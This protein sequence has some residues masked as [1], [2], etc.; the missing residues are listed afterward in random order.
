MLTINASTELAEFATNHVYSILTAL[1]YNNV[2]KQP[3][4]RGFCKMYYRSYG[5]NTTTERCQQFAFGGCDGNE[6]NFETERG[7]ERVCVRK[8]P[9]R[10]RRLRKPR[11][12]CRLEM[13]IDDRDCPQYKLVCDVKLWSCPTKINDIRYKNACTTECG[14]TEARCKGGKKCCKIGCSTICVPPVFGKQ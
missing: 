14:R 6:N 1:N 10:I 13:K 11:P 7:C 8:K 4:E 12:G 5:Y 9:C 2:C 3:I